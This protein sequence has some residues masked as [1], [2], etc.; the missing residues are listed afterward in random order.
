VGVIG[1]PVR[2]VEDARFLTGAAQFTAHV[3]VPG[4]RH[5]VYLRSPVAHAR[6]RAIDTGEARHLPGV[7]AVLTADDLPPHL[8]RFPADARALDG[9]MVRPFLAGGTVRYVGEPLAVVVADTL[10]AAR[11][12]ADAVVVDLDPL[13]PL[14]DP[15]RALDPGAPL[16]HPEAGTNECFTLSPPKGPPVTMDGCD[17]VIEARYHN[18]RL[19]PCTIEARAAATAWDG[20]Q[21]GPDRRLTLWATTQGPWPVQRALVDLYGLDP[22]AVRVVSPDV[23]GGFGAKEALYPEVLLLPWIADVVGAPVRWAEVRSESIVN[24][25]HGRGQHQTAT[26][27]GTRDGRILAYTL[28]LVA[29]AG[30]YPRLGATLLFLTRLVQCGPYRIPAAACTGRAVLT[31]TTP[32]LAYRGAGQPEAVA[33]LERSID[34]FARAIGLDPADVRRRNLLT[35][36]DY[37]YRSASGATY[38]SGHPDLAF[39]QCLERLGYD[40]ARAR[41]AE[42]RRLGDVRQLGIGLACFSEVIGGA[43]PTEYGSVEV[44]PDGTA[45]VR[46]GSFSHGQG[47]ETTWAMIVADRLGLPF[48][49]V[50]VID[51]DTAALPRGGNTGGSRSVQTA[52]NAIAEAS[53]RLAERARDLAADL[54]EAHPDDVVLDV[55]RGRFHVVGTPAVTRSWADVASA[56]TGRGEPL[57]AE[58][59]A[60]PA[61]RSA[62]TCGA[63]AAI[64]EVDTET[65]DVALLRV[66]AVTDAG[67][68]LNPLLAEGQIHGGVGQGVG[69]A[70]TEEMAYDDDGNPLTANFADYGVI[71]AAELADI[72]VSFVDIPA[73]FGPLGAKGLGES[74]AIGATAAVLNAAVDAVSHLGVE[75]I[76]L[77]LSARRVWEAIEAARGEM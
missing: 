64:V 54:L 38:D 7:D 39:E 24:L 71:S 15:R 26:L 11:D 3:D 55:D 14:V 20:D 25:G 23:G 6:L 5:V 33:A 43:E 16:L 21:Q 13:P 72:D 52:G 74:G 45:T 68:I 66:V 69:Q 49:Q 57:R 56:A 61:P 58:S 10:A 27:G 29:D 63:H 18:Q 36:D 53:T 34:R 67:R 75:D 62:F 37:P 9:P 51:G 50:R 46:A 73:P 2:R 32:V 59:E 40:E 12:A 44:A 19:A 76:G 28:D 35:A 47:H 30:A 4:A 8:G 70:L 1:R 65:G 77:P 60:G 41:Q 17:V 48:E 22:G 42:R 31:T